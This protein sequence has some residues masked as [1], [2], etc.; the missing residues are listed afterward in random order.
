[1]KSV[2]VSELVKFKK[3]FDWAVETGLIKMTEEEIIL[4][5]Y[6]VPEGM[7]TAVCVYSGSESEFKVGDEF[8]CNEPTSTYKIRLVRNRF[9][10]GKPRYTVVPINGGVWKFK[11]YNHLGE[12]YTGCSLDD[13]LLDEPSLGLAQSILHPSHGSSDTDCTCFEPVEVAQIYST[14]R[15]IPWTAVG[16]GEATPEFIQRLQRIPP[17]T[18]R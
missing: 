18:Q 15:S 10:S 14:E 7:Y 3:A 2:K 4:K 8:I 13:T 5:L 9:D 12:E 6:E 11:V 1:M 17:N 16:E